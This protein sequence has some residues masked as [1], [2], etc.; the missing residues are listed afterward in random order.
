MD[1]YDRE[2]H[3][4]T[5]EKFDALLADEDYVRVAQTDVGPYW[6][7]TVW[8]GL[9]HSLG[10]YPPV[11]FE[12]MVFVKDETSEDRKLLD[13]DAARY[14]TEH[15]ARVGHEDIVTLI[16]ATYVEDPYELEEEEKEEP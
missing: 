9:D 13:L 5:M 10:G 12:T 3:L 4:I 11:I 8:L 14:S 1:I 7:S 15:E 16:R 6:V 2:G